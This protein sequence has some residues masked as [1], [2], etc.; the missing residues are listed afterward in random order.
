[1]INEIIRV[2]INPDLKK[3]GFKKQGLTWNRKQGDIV[4]VFN[5]QKG[6]KRADGS[7]SFTL[8]LGICVQDIWE[9]CWAKSFPKLVKEEECFPRLRI[10]L[11]IGEFKPKILD[12]WWILSGTSDIEIVGLEIRKIINQKCLPFFKQFQTIE[13]VEIF[14]DSSIQIRFPLEKLYYSILKKLTGDDMTYRKIISEVENSEHW[15]TMAKKI[16]ERLS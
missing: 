12:K 4:H 2:Y 11:L 3:E 16:M 8:N 9:I 6:R 7:V 1:M 10:G 5:L 14:V 13:N 15:G